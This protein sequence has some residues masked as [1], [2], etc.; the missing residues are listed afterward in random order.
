MSADSS[1]MTRR[2]LLS[3][4]VAVAAGVLL[5]PGSFAA[6]VTAAAASIDSIAVTEKRIDA[7]ILGTGPFKLLAFPIHAD[8]ARTTAGQ[9]AWE[10][11]AAGETRISFDR[12]A[13]STDRLFQKFRL[14]D[15]ADADAAANKPIGA[16]RFA[17]DLRAL[18]STPTRLAWPVGIKGVSCP[19][20]VKD[21]AELGVKHAH[22]NLN[23]ADLVRVEERQR[24]EAASRVVD[25]QRIW[26]HPGGIATLDDSIRQLTEAGINILGVVT[27][28]GLVPGVLT[29]PKTDLQRAP[30]HMG[31]FNLSNDEGILHF[32]ALIEFLSDRY[33]R[34]DKHRGSVGGWIIGNEIQSTWEWHNMGSSTTDQVARQCA[35]EL[36]LAWFAV[37]NAGA[38]VPVF[39]SFDHFWGMALSADP[40]RHRPGRTLLDALA[41]LTFSEG[42]FPWHVAQH[43]YPENLFHP[44]FWLD[45]TATFAFDSP[46]ITFQNVELLADYLRRK[47]LLCDGKPRRL[48]LSEQGFHAGDSPESERMQAAAYALAYRRLS[49]I[50]AVEAFILH[51]HFDAPGE[52]GLKL[53]IWPS[54]GSAG[55]KRPI[56]KVVQTAD[57][58]G[59]QA[60]SDFALPLAGFQD[61]SQAAPRQGPFPEH[62]AK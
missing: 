14:F 39:A 15:A 22:V 25:G 17:D 56:W 13:G 61:W 31:A 16:P 19:V 43:P 57:T 18:S 10:G 52:G 7:V 58:P 34:G 23:A 12:F 38:D 8:A 21:L 4:A 53:G 40:T 60:D 59:W 51:R 50:P 48:I 36:R 46:R 24:T 26:F 33:C 41:A 37:R 44:E 3:G 5:P 20:D 47:E 27:H 32:R 42:N 2:N 28:H 30:N 62:V 54:T 1:S 45:R 49:Q 9:V 29:H 55:R 11:K 35:D 6:T